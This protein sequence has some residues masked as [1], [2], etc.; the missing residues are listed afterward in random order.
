MKQSHRVRRS[1][2]VSAVL[3]AVLFLLV[4]AAAEPF[5]AAAETVPA[6]ERPEE[7]TPAAQEQRDVSVQLRI[8]DGGEVRETDL[9]TYL[10]GVVRAEMPASFEMEA[11]KAQAVAA[12]TYTLYRLS[13]GGKHGETADLCTDHACCQAWMG[14]EE[15]RAVWGDAADRYEERVRRAVRETEG[16]AVLYDGAPVLAVFHSSSAGRT[17]PAGK[18]W[19]GDLPYLQA[20]DSPE[21]AARIPDY[22][23][24]AEFATEEFRRILQEARPE[25]DFSG[26]PSTW[27]RDS[28]ADS[29]GS[30]ERVTV[31]GVPMKG[32]E[33]RALLGLRSACFTWEAKEDTLVF[34]VTGYGHGV[35]MS[36][37]G[38][39]AM[40]AEGADYREILTHYYTG[41]EI[42]LWRG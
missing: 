3:M 33:L 12:R 13:G 38:A 18:V 36:Q 15:A 22:Y 4:P 5:E 8:L 41:T 17:R 42:G 40:A 24:R 39:E 21:E 30:V 16:Q 23:S 31:G 26:Q 10:V 34:Y 29:A 35:G 6:E 20:V 25:A 11:L 9:E 7:K 14:E 32:T 19:A 1:A 2:A 27:L 37:Y 28:V